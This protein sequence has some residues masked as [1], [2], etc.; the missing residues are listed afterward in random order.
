[1]EFITRAN[2]EWPR[3]R[4]FLNTPRRTIMRTERCLSSPFFRGDYL[5]NRQFVWGM[6]E[7]AIISMKMNISSLQFWQTLWVASL[8]AS[9][10]TPKP[11][12]H[13]RVPI[14]RSIHSQTPTA[15]PQTDRTYCSPYIYV[16]IAL[17]NAVTP[18]IRPS[19]SARRVFTIPKDIPYSD[20]YMEL[21]SIARQNIQYSLTALTKHNYIC[22]LY[23]QTHNSI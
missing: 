14:Y 2:R 16:R 6:R 19:K 5:T 12:T 4:F 8:R 21:H 7:C 22:R 13:N 3:W 23:K 11:R 1:M 9:S 17:N 10:L 18:T 20:W 15:E